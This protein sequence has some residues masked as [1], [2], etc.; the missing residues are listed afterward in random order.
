MRLE[1][2]EDEDHPAPWRSCLSQP[3]HPSRPH[4]LRRYDRHMPRALLSSAFLACSCIAPPQGS[5]PAPSLPNFVIVLADDMGDAG[6]SITGNPHFQTPHLDELARSGMRF[7]DFHSSGAV[8]SPTRAGLLTGRYQQRTG[9]DAVVNADPE[10][11][12]HGDF[13]ALEEITFAEALASRGYT[14]ALF[15]KWHVGYAPEHGPTLQGFD[16]FRGFVS[17]NIDYHSHHDRM[18]T[19][20]WWS[21]REVK[22]E[23]GYT[24]HLI[25]RHAIDFIERHHDRPFCLYLA[26]AAIH[27]PNQGPG[28]PP[29]RG[30]GARPKAELA[31]TADAVRAMTLALDEGVGQ[32]VSTLEQLGITEKTLVLFF[33]DNGGTRANRTTSPGTRGLKGSVW[34][35]GH[36]VP[37]IFSWPGVIEAGTISATTAISIDVMPTILHLASVPIPMDRQ[38]DGVDLSGVLLRGEPLPARPIFWEHGN[39]AAMR[40]GPWKL[41]VTKSR[42][43]LANLDQDPGEAEDLS[44]RHPDQLN[45]MMARL[46]AWRSEVHSNPDPA[47][48]TI[49]TASG[50]DVS[51]SR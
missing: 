50:G 12:D 36:R 20:D 32:I 37:A 49:S 18:G 14:S 22:D 9:V 33:S 31:P 39:Q 51:G 48:T 8:C 16:E 15:G 44:E 38:I 34:E 4:R 30:P 10:H 47:P 46:T 26:H 29:I 45:R 23:P 11:P 40:E 1:A 25:T 21:D 35:G 27:D 7:T 3:P 42:A 24:T 17:G 13:L 41:V 5:A 43:H 6:L 28:D 2:R 19:L